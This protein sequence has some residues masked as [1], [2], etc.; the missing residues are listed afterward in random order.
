MSDPCSPTYHDS[1]FNRGCAFPLQKVALKPGDTVLDLGCG[2][3]DEVLEAARLVQLDSALEQ[4]GLAGTL[5]QPPLETQEHSSVAEEHDG[6]VPRKASTSNTGLTMQPVQRGF[7]YG[8]DKNREA[9]MRAR[10]EATAKGIQNVCFVEGVIESLPFAAASVDV[11]ISNCVFNLS[12]NRTLALSEASRVLKPGGRLVI[13][14]IVS[15]KPLVSD[16]AA[17]LAASVFGCT[18]GVLA[19]DEYRLQVEEAGLRAVETELFQRFELERIRRRAATHS[20]VEVIAHLEDPAFAQR[21]HGLF[22]SAY[23][24]A[25]NRLEP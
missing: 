18:Q 13:A 7:A 6:Q 10:S 25:T 11:V 4:T 1:P 15:L 23:I 20:L 24:L 16:E 3:G 21:V 9:L 17:Q 8:L 22:A 5:H 12:K 14:D 2:C 19:L